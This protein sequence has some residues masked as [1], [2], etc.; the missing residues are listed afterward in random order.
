MVCESVQDVSQLGDPLNCGA[1]LHA[2]GRWWC[3]GIATTVVG[4]DIIGQC[5]GVFED[6]HMHD[7]VACWSRTKQVLTV[8]CAEIQRTALL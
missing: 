4:L 3:V 1:G 8:P 6:H 7:L 5:M 2:P